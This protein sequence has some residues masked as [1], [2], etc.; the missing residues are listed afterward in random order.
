RGTGRTGGAS[1]PTVRPPAIAALNSRA[2][3][4]YE[5]TSCAR[6]AAQ[7]RA[8]SSGG[9]T[10]PPARLC[11]SS[12]STSVV[13]GEITWPRGLDAAGEAAGGEGPPS[14]AAGEREARVSAAPAG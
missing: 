10:T 5:A 3:S 2:P 6:A 11:V 14:P 8:A 13:G 12:I 9:K 7:M 1:A 4:R